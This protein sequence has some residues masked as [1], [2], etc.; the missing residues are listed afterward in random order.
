MADLAMRG[1]ATS[2]EQAKRMMKSFQTIVFLQD[3]K[4]Q[5]ISEIVGYDEEKKDMI[6][7]PI[8]RR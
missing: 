7:K 2:Y 5:E 6:Y 1:Y 4:V 8:Y 3:F